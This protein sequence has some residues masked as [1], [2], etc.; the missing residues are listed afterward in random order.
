MAEP[1]KQFDFGQNWQ[2][3]SASALTPGKVA[4]AR[5]HFKQ[6]ISPLDVRARYFLDIGFGQGLSLLI[7]TEL[8]ARAAGCDINP[9]C[10]AVL[11]ANRRYF[12][13]VN[14][15][16]SVVVGS[17]LDEKIVAELRRQATY[18]G[19]VDGFDF[20]HSWGVLHHTGDMEKALRHATSLVKPGGHFIVAIYNRHWSSRAWLVIKRIYVASPPLVQKTMVG[21]FYPVIYL[22]KWAVTGRNPRKQDRGMN[23][24]YDIIDWVGGYPYEYAS[25]TEMTGRLR[26]LGFSLR[27]CLPATVPTGC[28]QFVFQHNLQGD[29]T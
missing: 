8:G 7:A 6:L 13:E 5:E 15:P 22:A 23:F 14:S 2:E 17:I 11:D 24:Y 28:N 21:I 29:L 3:F 1:S 26:S 19:C 4:Q 12:P 25:I 16:P 27:K 18:A 20:V 9:K 10:A